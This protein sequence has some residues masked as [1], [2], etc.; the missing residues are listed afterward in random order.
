VKA[1]AIIPTQQVVQSTSL[2]P[3]DPLT[4]IVYPTQ[5]QSTSEYYEDDGVSFEY[6][7][8]T[9]LKRIINQ[10]RSSSVITITLSKAEG[11][12]VPP[13]RSLV[14]QCVAVESAPGQIEIDGKKLESTKLED[15]YAKQEGWSY[16][17]SGRLLVIKTEDKTSGRT[18]RV[19]R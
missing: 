4:L 19:L 3:I 8:G 6:E 1:G 5:L 17:S 13:K 18:I 12:Y 14:V 7:K 9:Y 11:S 10:W 16:D 2:A 15:L